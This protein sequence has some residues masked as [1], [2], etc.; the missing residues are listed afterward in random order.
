MA[1]RNNISQVRS[2]RATATHLCAVG[3]ASH[4]LKSIAVNNKRVARKA[5]F[6][7]KRKLEKKVKVSIGVSRLCNTHLHAVI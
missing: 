6:H 2:C 5:S 3:V 7:L 4:G 1:V